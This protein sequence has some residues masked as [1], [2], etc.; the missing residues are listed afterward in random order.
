LA[1]E[2][3]EFEG[4]EI[5]VPKI[6]EEKIQIAYRFRQ[7][8]V[9]QEARQGQ[10]GQ[11]LPDRFKASNREEEDIQGQ[12][13]DSKRVKNLPGISAKKRP[14]FQANQEIFGEDGEKYQQIFG[15]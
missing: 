12:S 3:Q 7:G 13:L 15:G 11:A 4:Q 10:I 2:L 8:P 9:E 14:V 5:E 6:S 1:E